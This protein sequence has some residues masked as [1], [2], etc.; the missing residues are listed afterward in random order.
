MNGEAQTEARVTNPI[1]QPTEPAAVRDGLVPLVDVDQQE[2]PGVLRRV[3][4]INAG[5]GPNSS[6]E[7]TAT[8]VECAAVGGTRWGPRARRNRDH[9]DPRAIRQMPRTQGSLLDRL[10][11]GGGLERLGRGAFLRGE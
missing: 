7:R 3:G 1:I 6:G 8:E 10:V 11:R 4:D 9:T 5:R 2:G